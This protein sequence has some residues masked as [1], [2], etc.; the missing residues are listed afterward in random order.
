M[1]YCEIHCCWVQMYCLT[2]EIV[3]VLWMPCMVW[4]FYIEVL[5]MLFALS[6]RKKGEKIL[7]RSFSEIAGKVKTEI[8]LVPK[9]E[10]AIV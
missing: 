2:S 9:L 10:L 8:F 6:M 7:G 1:Q 5:N 4:L 3:E